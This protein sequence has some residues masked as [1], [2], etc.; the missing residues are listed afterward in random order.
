LLTQLGRATSV[1][2]GSVANIHAR[3]A[4]PTGK[5][6]VTSARSA[7]AS[8]AGSAIDA[9]SGSVASISATAKIGD[10]NSLNQTLIRSVD[11][12]PEIPIHETGPLDS[13]LTVAR[14]RQFEKH[15]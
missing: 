2:P 7:S 11:F 13:T 1:T 10:E 9:T 6:T 4:S 5:E 8:R 14:D 15:V 12:D 3:A